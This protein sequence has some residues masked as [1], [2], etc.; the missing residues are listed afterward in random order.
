[1]EAT[2]SDEELESLLRNFHRV[3]Q[4]LAGSMAADDAAIS[5]FGS[6]SSE[7]G[8]ELRDG[9]ISEL[10]RGYEAEVASL[11]PTRARR[12][13]GQTP[14]PDSDAVFCQYPPEKDRD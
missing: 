1:M 13:S 7:C 5:L 14:T 9:G 2:A 12:A 6:S 10:G 8:R 3:S 11:A 4:V